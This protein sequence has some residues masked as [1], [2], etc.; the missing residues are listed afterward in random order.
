MGNTTKL[1]SRGPSLAGLLWIL[2]A[3]T[4][5][6]TEPN[7]ARI[8]FW[9]PP[10]RMEEFEASYEQQVV[11]LLQRRGLNPSSHQGRATPDSVFS[12]LL[13]IESLDR[14][15][16]LQADPDSEWV[17]VARSLG[18]RF[19]TQLADNLIRSLLTTYQV[20]A[21]SGK[22]VPAGPGKTR[23]ARG[24]GHW[25]TF[26]GSDG[27]VVGEIGSIA[28]DGEGRIW[29]G[30][31]GQVGVSRFDGR[32]F[33]TFTTKDGLVHNYV[34]GMLL[35]RDG[36]LWIGTEGGVSRYDGEHFTNYT[37]RDGLPHNSFR[38]LLQDREGHIWFGN[39][40]GWGALRY[41]GERFLSFTMKD[42]LASNSIGRIIE[43]ADG[44]IWFAGAA[45]RYDGERF[46]TPR[47]RP[48]PAGNRSVSVPALPCGRPGRPADSRGS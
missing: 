21:G 35:D 28:E 22:S 20:K 33:E 26:D 46:T 45:T 47:L 17:A 39:R 32:R 2:I 7:L 13:E 24:R 10:E 8:A 6:A 16:A 43:D 38:P 5:W 3:G 30:A 44:N 12:R 4:G 9:V 25:R 27:L 40:L 48:C 41:D 31:W 29:I 19:S 18:E 36:H 1:T 14:F 23:I 34:G 42:G 37:T 11:P 15:L